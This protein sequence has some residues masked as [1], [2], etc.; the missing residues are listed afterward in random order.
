[1]GGAGGQWQF[2]EA[3]GLETVSSRGCAG[4]GKR[5]NLREEDEKMAGVAGG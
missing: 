5:G 4:E 1:M 2:V 3:T